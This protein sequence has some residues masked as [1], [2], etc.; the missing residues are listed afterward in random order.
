[1][2]FYCVIDVVSDIL[3]RDKMDIEFNNK[4]VMKAKIAQ[5]WVQTQNW[6]DRVKQWINLISKPTMVAGIPSISEYDNRY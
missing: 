5:R 2:I 4:W 3:L 1:V 6:D